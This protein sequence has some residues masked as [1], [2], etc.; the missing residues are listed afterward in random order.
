MTSDP[1]RCLGRDAN[2]RQCIC[3]RCTKTHEEGN[4]TV[5]SNCGHI[6]SAHPE[7]RV[8]VGSLIKNYRDTGKLGKVAPGISSSS[9]AK[10][11]QSEAEAETNKGL[12]RKSATDTEPPKKPSKS[13]GKSKDEQVRFH[14]P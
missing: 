13:K 4:Q 14:E 5:C 6:E 3:Q 2:D 1:S 9:T 7:P 10:A 12:K 11:S 8:T